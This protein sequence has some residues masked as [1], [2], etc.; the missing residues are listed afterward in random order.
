MAELGNG[1]GRHWAGSGQSWSVVVVMVVVVMPRRYSRLSQNPT[2][3]YV[4]V[5]MG[6]A[7]STVAW[8]NLS[9]RNRVLRVP[10]HLPPWRVDVVQER[11]CRSRRP[12]HLGV[13]LVH[14]LLLPRGLELLELTGDL[15]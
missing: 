10:R 6:A 7:S 2:K 13:C 8:T 9:P 12:R 14:P 11:W 5:E 1:V 4:G 3:V 15:M